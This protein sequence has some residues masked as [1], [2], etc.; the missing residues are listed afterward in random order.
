MTCGG[1]FPSERFACR[2]CEATTSSIT[3]RDTDEAS[4]PSE[5]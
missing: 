2:P 3:S 4:T 1:S 5:I